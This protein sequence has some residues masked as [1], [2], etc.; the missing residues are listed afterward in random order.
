M[1]IHPA[2]YRSPGHT[3]PRCSAPVF[4]ISRRFIDV[5]F[6][7]FV[8]LRRYRCR[9]MQCGWEGYFRDKRPRSFDPGQGRQYEDSNYHILESSR[10]KQ[11]VLSE[12]KPK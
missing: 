11:T 1:N 7:I 2:G 8:P 9:S 10:M 4:R 3:C 12:K 5:M 6:S